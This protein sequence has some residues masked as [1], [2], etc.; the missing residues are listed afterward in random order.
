V[1]SVRERTDS[2]EGVL[3]PPPH[4]PCSTPVFSIDR[5]FPAPETDG[6]EP[7]H[8]PREDPPCSASPSRSPHFSR[9]RSQ[10]SPPTDRR[11]SCSSPPTTPGG[12]T[13]GAT[14]RSTSRRHTWT[15]SP[16]AA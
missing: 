12:P 9:S 10:H 4:S 6:D 8:L 1:E 2:G 11:T 5:P 7:V 13:S 15:G 3:H 14:A 16:K